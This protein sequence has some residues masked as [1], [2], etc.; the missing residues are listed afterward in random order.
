MTTYVTPRA[1]ADTGPDPAYVPEPDRA[2][3]V[4]HLASTV[5][6]ALGHATRHLTAA[7]AA[8]D[9]D[10]ARY[11][12]DRAAHHAGRAAEHQDRLMSALASYHPAVGAEL[13]ELHRV[14]QPPYLAPP[15]PARAADTEFDYD[16]IPP[17]HGAPQPAG[18]L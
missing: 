2:R 10:S 8:P 1:M 14:T 13:G 17:R 15:A 18:E 12:L 3:T 5:R 4:A 9:S 6:D 11:N 16:I 7:Q